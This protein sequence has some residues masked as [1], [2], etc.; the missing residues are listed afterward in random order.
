MTFRT[1]FKFQINSIS[2][3]T[4]KVQPYFLFELLWYTLNQQGMGVMCLQNHLLLC[5]WWNTTKNV[6]IEINDIG[7]VE[8]LMPWIWLRCSIKLEVLAYIKLRQRN[9]MPFLCG[10]K[11]EQFHELSSQT[12]EKMAKQKKISWKFNWIQALKLS[13]IDWI[14][15]IFI[16]SSHFALVYS[17][18]LSEKA[19][20]FRINRRHEI[21][22]QND[23]L[24]FSLPPQMN[25]SKHEMQI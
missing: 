21:W 14:M 13:F 8:I 20:P 19:V 10:I 22:L 3:T 16:L 18:L 2:H 4:H 12:H 6:Q 1:P 23:A 25:I 7:F 11:V 24:P 15:T 17:I 9:N 5:M